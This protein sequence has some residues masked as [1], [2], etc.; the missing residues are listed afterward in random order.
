VVASGRPYAPQVPA[1]GMAIVALQVQ[2]QVEGL[3]EGILKLPRPLM[4]HPADEGV[5][6][7]PPRQPCLPI[8]EGQ[9]R[10]AAHPTQHQAKSLGKQAAKRQPQRRP[11]GVERVMLAQPP[12]E[13]LAAGAHATCRWGLWGD[14]DIQQGQAGPGDAPGGIDG[15]RELLEIPG[16]RAR[17]CRDGAGSSKHLG[18]RPHSFWPYKCSSSW[19]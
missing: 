13:V 15:G 8:R 16:V 2:R 14:A 10:A 9:P 1:E 11:V 19:R 6:R 5:V 3:D 18:P 4:S 12:P 7:H 17:H